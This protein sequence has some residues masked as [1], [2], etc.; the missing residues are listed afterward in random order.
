MRVTLVNKSAPAQFHVCKVLVS[1]AVKAE[2][3]D[4][5]VKTV[6]CALVMFHTLSVRRH[7]VPT[8]AKLQQ[9]RSAKEFG[10]CYS[11]LGDIA[12]NLSK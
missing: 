12:R 5:N 6:S 7:S 4:Q 10:G 3:R 9:G 8:I 1:L 2:M 11:T